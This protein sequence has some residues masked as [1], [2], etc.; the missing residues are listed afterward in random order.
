MVSGR[1]QQARGHP[2][3][4]AGVAAN[5]INPA[6]RWISHRTRRAPCGRRRRRA[7][8]LVSRRGHRHR[9]PIP[10][11]DT[12][13]RADRA[14]GVAACAD[15]GRGRAGCRAAGAAGPRGARPG[16]ARQR[17]PALPEGGRAPATLRLTSR[18]AGSGRL[19]V[20]APRRPEQRDR[21]RAR[22]SLSTNSRSAPRA[23]AGPRRIRK[24]RH[25]PDHGRRQAERESLRRRG[26][27]PR[28]AAGVQ[29]PGGGQLCEAA[30]GPRR[31]TGRSM[32]DSHR[33]LLITAGEWEAFVDD[34]NQTLDKFDVPRQERSEVL[35]IID[36][37]R[38]DI[39][40]GDESG[41]SR[42]AVEGARKPSTQH[43][44]WTV[45][46]REAA[47]EEG[48]RPSPSRRDD[49]CQFLGSDGFRGP[50]SVLCQ[51]GYLEG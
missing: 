29:V 24:R 34:L 3:G 15:R 4:R 38:D 42:S 49:G 1:A 26:A 32:H 50:V 40:V 35:A 21:R 44:R 11:R 7:V 9:S 36:S 19:V 22:P 23:R 41:R 16:A 25:R 18:V 48:G 31:Y 30:G 13:S 51:I 43:E 2:T 10:G 46:K 27:S 28:V 8:R 6:V 5:H 39:V 14:R 20:G 45:L 33:D 12:H 37:T 47:A 17:E